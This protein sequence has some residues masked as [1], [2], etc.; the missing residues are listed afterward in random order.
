MEQAGPYGEPARVREP[1][2]SPSPRG[3]VAVL[4]DTRSGWA[5]SGTGTAD[6]YG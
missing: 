5:F 6:R 2:G 3:L 1:R 4:D